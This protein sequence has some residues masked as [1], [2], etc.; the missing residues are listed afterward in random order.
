[1]NLVVP[2]MM[3]TIGVTT[4][5]PVQAQNATPDAT[6]RAVSTTQVETDFPRGGW[7]GNNLRISVTRSSKLLPVRKK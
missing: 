1:M 4:I 5:N 3:L 6:G 2:A 7:D